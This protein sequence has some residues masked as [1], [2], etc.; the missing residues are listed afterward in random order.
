MSLC[1]LWKGG[2]AHREEVLLL[3]SNFASVALQLA[4]TCFFFFFLFFTIVF[5]VYLFPVRPLQPIALQ[6]PLPL[7]L[8]FN[9][10]GSAGN[11][12]LNG[13]QCVSTFSEMQTALKHFH[14]GINVGT[15][16]VQPRRICMCLH[17]LCTRRW[18]RW[19]RIWLDKSFGVWLLLTAALILSPP[20]D[21]A[22]S[23]SWSKTSQ[24]SVE[25]CV[26]L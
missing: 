8:S 26:A 3:F 20:E 21:V 11:A 12:V 25:P 13:W 9:G 10:C 16:P 6:L 22:L 1:P 7:P 18:R 15:L 5:M 23:K 2:D 17:S 4:L 19:R 14:T 24:V